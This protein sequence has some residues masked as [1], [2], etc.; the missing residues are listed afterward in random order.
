[1]F[2]HWGLYSGPAGIWKDKKNKHPYAEWLQA[3][4]HVPRAEYRALAAAF[5]PVAFDADAWIKEAAHAGMRYF[6]ITAKH[7]DGFALWPSQASTFNVVDATP[8]KRDILKELTEAC[9]RHGLKIGFYY[10]HWM[11]WEGVGGDVCGV[12]MVNEEYVHPTQAEFEHYWQSK[13]LPQVRE[14]IERYNPWFLWFDS[15]GESTKTFITDQRQDELISLIRQQSDRCLVNSRIRFDSPSD[16]VDFLSMMD[17]CYPE[18][19]FAKPWETSGTLNDSWAYHAL[20]YGW[21]STRE[22]LRY[23]I[24]NASFGGNYQLNVGPTGDGRFQAAAIKRLREIGCWMRINGESIYDTQAGP[25][26]KT[27]WGRSTRKRMPDGTT[28]LYLHLF[29]FTPGTALFIPPLKTPPRQAV[30]LE[31]GQPVTISADSHGVWLAL[32][33]ELR[34]LDLPV[35][36]LDVPGPV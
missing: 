9:E 20:D 17:N 31:S 1:M 5:N 6:V 4:E 18:N 14:L 2:V 15:W 26:G 11:D 10:S 16:R 36:R 22:L 19:A 34:G 12:H 29:D 3:S 13:C 33:N 25:F 27:P 28:R 30:V 23:L 21:K 24:G 7:H 35:I 8:F 32:P